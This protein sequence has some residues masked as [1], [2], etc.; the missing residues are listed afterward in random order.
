MLHTYSAGTAR[1]RTA[2]NAPTTAVAVIVAARTRDGRSATPRLPPSHPMAPA[3]NNSPPA[4]DR[5]RK[6]GMPRSDRRATQSLLGQG[7]AV[8]PS[9]ASDGS[10]GR[11]TAGY[12]TAQLPGP[13][14]RTGSATE[15]VRLFRHCSS[16]PR[17][18]PSW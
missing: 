9:L 4:A 13:T 11:T 12:T 7:L 14:P 17:P 8:I 18:L 3:R 15:S 1:R 10:S 6:A 16:R 2:S 5:S